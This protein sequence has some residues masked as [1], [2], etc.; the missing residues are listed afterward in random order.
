M[1]RTPDTSVI[2]LIHCVCSASVV[3]K[4]SLSYAAGNWMRKPKYFGFLESLGSLHVTRHTDTHLRTTAFSRKY[5]LEGFSASGVLNTKRK[6]LC[7][8]AK[9]CDIVLKREVSYNSPEYSFTSAY[10]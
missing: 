2:A 3:Q 8:R 5:T 7:T 6:L 9:Q 10:T 4:N 1:R